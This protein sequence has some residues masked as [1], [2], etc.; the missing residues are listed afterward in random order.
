ML[1][2]KAESEEVLKKF[3]LFVEGTVLVAHNADF[4]S[5]TNNNNKKEK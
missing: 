2:G 3:M 5:V 4:D 1:K